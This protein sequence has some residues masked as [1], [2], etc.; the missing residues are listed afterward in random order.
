MIIA[1][2]IILLFIALR[3]YGESGIEKMESLVLK[4]T[5]K[6][7]KRILEKKGSPI[8]PTYE[9]GRLLYKKLAH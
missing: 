6:M 8:D 5:G 3:T 9:Y 7:R 4:E 1:I 2:V